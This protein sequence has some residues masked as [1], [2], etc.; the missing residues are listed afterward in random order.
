MQKVS[1]PNILRGPEEGKYL[2]F[3]A[4][5]SKITAWHTSLPAFQI[6]TSRPR[7]WSRKAG[8]PPAFP[9]CTLKTLDLAGHLH[10]YDYSR[11]C[12]STEGL[13]TCEPLLPRTC[14][15]DTHVAAPSSC[16][17]HRENQRGLDQR[18]QRTSIHGDS[19]K[20]MS[21]SICVAMCCGVRSCQSRWIVASSCGNGVTLPSETSVTLSH[22]PLHA[23]RAPPQKGREKI[24]VDPGGDEA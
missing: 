4:A 24:L 17:T 19:S 14:R 20:V 21:P 10:R 8:E 2:L 7:L 16:G 12:S 5:L 15:S 9:T 13:E 22:T 3:D 1:S 11:V 6:S 23:I 18:P